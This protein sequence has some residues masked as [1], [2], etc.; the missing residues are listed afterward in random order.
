[1]M[2]EVE[3]FVTEN[4]L[5]DIV[6][7]LRKDTLAAR[8][9]H[10]IKLIPELDEDDRHALREEVTHRWKHPENLYFTLILSSIAAA[11]QG[12]VQTGSGGA[13]LSWPVALGTPDSGPVR[14]A[15]SNCEKN[16]WLVGFVNSCLYLSFFS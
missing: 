13:N 6:K 15:A 1:M 14:E 2:A 3:A 16:S 5:T 10:S 12:W 7:L 9:P 11:I 8:S 4:G